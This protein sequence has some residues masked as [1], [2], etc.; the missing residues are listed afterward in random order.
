M[1]YC[2]GIRLNAGLVFLADTRTN[3]G[4]DQVSSCRK[5]SVFE[6]P[7]ERMLVLMTAGNLS[8]SQSV[9]HIVCNQAGTDGVNI[10]T[11]PDMHV[12][13][14]IVGDAV[15]TVHQQEAALLGA[16]GVDF[17][18]S[19]VLGG[20]IKGERSRLFYIYAAGNFI[21]SHDAN[22]YFQ[23]GEAKYGKPILD[24][25]VTPATS[26]DDAAKCALISMDSTLRSNVSVGLPLD[27]LVYEED[28][29]AVTR[30]VTIDEQNQYFHLLRT[31]WGQQLKTVFEGMDAPVWDA[32][33]G[34]AGNMPS[35]ANLHST[36]LRMSV[37]AGLQAGVAPA[38]LQALA[39]QALTQSKN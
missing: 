20:Q 16:F 31:S 26:L 21:E 19:V 5:L 23:I 10:W 1:T 8:I 4:V 11:A 28:S 22:T 18:I 6:N 36:P 2:V 30:F 37:P 29:L 39:G 27:M 17:N 7:G 24:R 33:P 32:A 25:V 14:R 12:A 38:P 35:A 34:T 13:A 3:A 15:R 9:L